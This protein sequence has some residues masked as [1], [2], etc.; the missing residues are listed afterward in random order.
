MHLW[1]CVSAGR[2]LAKLLAA[3]QAAVYGSPAGVLTADLWDSVL[4][5]KLFEHSERQLFKLGHHG[6]M[7]PAVTVSA[8]PKA[9][10]A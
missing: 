4:E 6:T 9:S 1:L 10:A 3:V 5:R 7:E 8:V 2:E